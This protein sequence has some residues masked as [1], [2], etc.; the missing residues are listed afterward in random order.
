MAEVKPRETSIE[1]IKV[2]AE[3]GH[4]KHIYWFIVA[5]TAFGAFLTVYIITIYP[6]ELS[7]RFADTGLIFW[8]S[9]AVSG[10]I[11]YLIGSSAMQRNRPTAPPGTVQ[12]DVSAT[13]T[14]QPETK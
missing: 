8:L 2:Q 13:I 11:G 1:S 12:A 3:D 4:F 9:T 7:S 10:G 5:L 14:S 6:K